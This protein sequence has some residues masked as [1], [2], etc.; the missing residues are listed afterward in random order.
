YPYIKVIPAFVDAETRAKITADMAAAR[1]RAAQIEALDKDFVTIGVM[2]RTEESGEMVARK[3]GISIRIIPSG[4]SSVLVTISAEAL[5]GRLLES[6]QS[7][8]EF[9]EKTSNLAQVKTLIV[10]SGKK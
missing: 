3:G 10:E 7:I 1:E 8:A 2:T 5:P 6:Y 9:R 4:A